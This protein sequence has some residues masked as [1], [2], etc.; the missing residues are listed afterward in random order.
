MPKPKR[1]LPPN[2]W[3]HYDL[4]QRIRRA[5]YALSTYFRTETFIS[6][7]PAT[8]ILTLGSALGATIEDQTVQALN[9]MR[10]I[11]DPEENYKLYSFVRQGQTF[12][13]VLLRSKQNGED[14]II[15]IELKGWYLLAKEA[16]PNFRYLVTKDACALQD[17]VVVVPWVLANVL[18]G[19]PMVFTPYVESAR[20]AAEYRNYYWQELRQTSSS[21]KIEIPEGVIPYPKKS[22][23][24]ADKPKADSGNNFG[25]IARTGIMDDY[26]KNVM[27]QLLRGIPAE[28]W[29]KF[30]KNFAQ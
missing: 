29:V 8:D 24:I 16:E 26:V 23:K 27:G 18:S 6:G 17:L 1:E 20:Y 5:I 2:D 21:T 10:P 12:P 14:I 22:D 28:E 25:R 19:A 13:D 3:E 9:A 11:W 30:F 4:Y 15:G 7:I